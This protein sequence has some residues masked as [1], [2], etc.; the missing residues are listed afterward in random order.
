MKLRI[1]AI[2][3]AVCC[4][5]GL[6]V[7]LGSPPAVAN[8]SQLVAAGPPMTLLLIP[9]DFEY[10]GSKK[11]KMCHIKVHKSWAK[12]KMA[13]TFEQL[14]PGVDAEAKTKAGL[15]PQKDY[16]K[17][18]S[19]LPCHV[20]GWGKKGGYAIPDEAD[21]KAVK[22]AKDLEG[23]GCEACHGPGSAYSKVHKEIQK[24]KRTYKQ[25]ELFAVGMVKQ[26]AKACIDCHNDK[27]PTYDASKPFDFEKE[28]DADTH[29]HE[30]LK[31][32]EG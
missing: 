28:K 29:E 3:T 19:C 16:T 10:V 27:S 4:V 17:D 9:D 24:S 20:T 8:G 22:K 12:T 32:R 31:Q 30:E 11:C 1:V 13:K 26:D 21:K 25:E 15:D 2:L 14:K 6:S 7:W 18:E 23:V 5:V